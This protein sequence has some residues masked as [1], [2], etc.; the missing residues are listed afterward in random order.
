MS[1]SE[2]IQSL[3]EK[4]NKEGVEK[5]RAQATE[6]IEAAQKEAAKIVADAKAEAADEKAA[7]QRD[8]ERY[9]LGATE[10][11]RQAA[12]DMIANVEQ[13]VTAFLEN[14]LLKNVDLSLASPEN[15][16]KLV[17][18][19]VEGV[20]KSGEIVCNKE[21]AQALQAQL[22]SLKNFTV[23]VDETSLSGFS[24]KLDGG[25]I[26]HDFTAQTIAGEL[27]KRL[28]PDLAALMK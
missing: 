11:L 15:A 20:A 27:A 19:A 16:A 3:L 26:E 18:A 22:A 5:A 13:S 9:M 4:I 8:A 10:T 14:L 28:R 25:R 7:A 21:I 2:D 1:M 17:C 12:R 6:I 24:V 23:I